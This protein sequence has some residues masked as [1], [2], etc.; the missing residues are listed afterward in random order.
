[1]V[2]DPVGDFIV[3]IKNA[4]AVGKDVVSAPHSK[5]RFAIAEALEKKGYLKAVHKKVKK[6]QKTIEVTLR[7][8]KHDKP[9]IHNIKRM[10]RPGRRLY[11]RVHDIHPVKYGKGSL[12]L[13]TPEGIVADDEARKKKIGGEALFMIW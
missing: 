6:A 4:S 13:S 11:Y 12:I 10:S 1:M 5:L 7:Y 3:R 8:D 9:V 2:S